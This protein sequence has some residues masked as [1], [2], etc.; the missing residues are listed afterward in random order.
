[1]SYIMCHLLSNYYAQALVDHVL[2]VGSVLASP[3]VANVPLLGRLHTQDDEQKMALLSYTFFARELTWADAFS[4]WLY[5]MK[6]VLASLLGLSFLFLSKGLLIRLDDFYGAPIEMVFLSALLGMECRA[7]LSKNRMRMVVQALCIAI[8]MSGQV[9]MRPHPE[10]LNKLVLMRAVAW[11]RE[12]MVIFD[13]DAYFVI[14]SGLLLTKT[15]EFVAMA[16]VITMLVSYGL[17]R[18]GKTLRCAWGFLIRAVLIYSTNGLCM[19]SIGRL[20]IS[21]GEVP[22]A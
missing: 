13:C 1:M 6:L 14:G 15:L 16:A 3:Q 22:Q 18:G 9:A 7:H 8:D 5:Y 19:I 11:L 20:T 4:F 2:L 17:K 21:I 12:A 10:H